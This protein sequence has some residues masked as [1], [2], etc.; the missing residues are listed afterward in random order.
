MNKLSVIIL[1][2]QVNIYDYYKIADVIVLPSRV[3]PFPFVM[4]ETGLMKKPFIGSNVDGI[5]ELI[6]HKV[7]GL[8][9]KS[10]NVGELVSTLK[11]I[12]E[13]EL[14]AQRMADNLYEDVYENY[15]V[16]KVIPEYIKLYNSFTR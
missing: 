6:K 10:E 14:F 1:K 11:I 9:F 4:L 5:P 16:T 12:L 2:P 3:D 7:N 8:L 13:D 15:T